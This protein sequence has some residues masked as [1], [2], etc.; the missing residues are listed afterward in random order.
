MQIWKSVNIFVL[1]WK[2]YVED[3]TL[4]H[5][6]LSELCTREIC[7][8]FVYKHS[9]RIEHVK[10]WGL[11]DLQCEIFRVLFLYE[12][13][14]IGR[15]SNLHMCTFKFSNYSVAVETMRSLKLKI[16]FENIAAV[17]F[18]KWYWSSKMKAKIL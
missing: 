5:L 16:F 7:E 12:H 10:N 2:Q 8:K 15:S 3:F 17:V 13:K 4:K 14:R 9:E 11:L 6:L 18:G 1:I